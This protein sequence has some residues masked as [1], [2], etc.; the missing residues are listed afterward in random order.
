MQILSSFLQLIFSCPLDGMC[1]TKWVLLF[2]A[3]SPRQ[4]C[5]ARLGEEENGEHHV[6]DACATV[7]SML[8]LL[9]T[10]AFCF[11]CVSV[12]YDQAAADEEAD[13]EPTPTRE[14]PPAK[15]ESSSWGF[16]SFSSML[17]HVSFLWG[18]DSTDEATV[19]T[20]TEPIDRLQDNLGSGEGSY[21]VASESPTTSSQ[22]L[23]IGVTETEPESLPTGTSDSPRSSITQSNNDTL[24]SDSYSPTSSAVRDTLFTGSPA[25]TGAPEQNATHTLPPGGTAQTAGPG[26]G[27]TP[28]HLAGEL[29]DKQRAED[30]TE[31]IEPTI[32][33]ETTVPAALTWEVGQTTTTIPTLVETALTSTESLGPVAHP[34]SPETTLVTKPQL[35]TVSVTESYPAQSESDPGAAE[36]RSGP[37]EE[38]PGVITTTAGTQREP[39]PTESITSTTPSQ[40]VDFP[41]DG[42]KRS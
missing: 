3:I 42:G 21:P 13:W 34:E 15:K 38:L 1:V 12:L 14:D 4:P 22:G 27:A 7:D 39:V 20:T 26:M 8:R 11:W 32:A 40:R 30:F 24:V 9:R 41:I 6:T 10:L 25:S 33:P 17:S 18:S 36:A 16:G 23:L 35:S 2:Q 28:R 5:Q 29:V 37:V 31:K 19:L